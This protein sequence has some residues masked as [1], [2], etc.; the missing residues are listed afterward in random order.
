MNGTP[1]LQYN[2]QF[3]PTPQ[4]NIELRPADIYERVQGIFI[5]YMDCMVN[6]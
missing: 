4:E 5:H 3:V 6:R 2:Y 1:V